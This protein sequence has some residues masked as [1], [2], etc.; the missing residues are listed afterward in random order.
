VT[1]FEVDTFFQNYASAFSRFD[2]DEICALWAYPAYMTAR[3]KR[4]AL[5]AD[6]FQA[7]THALC[8]FYK[9]QGIAQATKQLLEIARFTATTAT[10]RTADRILDA[11]DGCIAEWEHVYLVSETVDGLRAVAAA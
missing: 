3:G 8:A 11:S 10:V 4:A 5:D 1:A 7:N 9:A 6:A 2:V